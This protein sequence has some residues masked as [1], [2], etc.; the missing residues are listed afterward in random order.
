MTPA[1]SQRLHALR[2]FAALLVVATHANQLGYTG[3]SHG[4]LEPLGRLGVIVFFVLSG[5]VIAHV[6]ETRH[7]NL[8]SYMLARL[9][10]L[11]S[12]LIPVADL[13]GSSLAPSLYARFPAVRDPLALA[14]APA[15]ASF[16]Y[17]SFGNGLR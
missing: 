12:V 8:S 14:T 11:N 1:V 4:L 10:R 15:F 2:L 6:S 3:S 5:Y 13:V 9:G 16:M 17:Q 7:R